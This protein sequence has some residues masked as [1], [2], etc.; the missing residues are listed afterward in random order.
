PTLVVSDRRPDLFDQCGTGR[1]HRHT[2]ENGTRRVAYD[3]CDAALRPGECGQ[4]EERRHHDESWDPAGLHRCAPFNG[5]RDPGSGTRDGDVGAYMG[6]VS[7]RPTAVLA[8]CFGGL[9][10]GPI[11]SFARADLRAFHDVDESIVLFVTGKFIDARL[12]ARPDIF[13]RPRPGPGR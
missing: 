2:G 6:A 5:I 4:E 9:A 10:R 7:G 11:A 8:F 12:D 1:L 13:R 3:S